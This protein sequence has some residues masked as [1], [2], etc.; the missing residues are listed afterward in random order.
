MYLQETNEL[1]APD[2]VVLLVTPWDKTRIN[3]VA[4]GLY[5]AHDAQLFVAV[6]GVKVGVKRLTRKVLTL[7][8][9]SDPYDDK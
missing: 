3:I 1:R 2:G 8:F 4:W 6:A 5:H 9:G 7:M